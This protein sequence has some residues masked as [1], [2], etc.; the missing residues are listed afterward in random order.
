MLFG[1][2]QDQQ[3]CIM[4][5]ILV[6]LIIMQL[7]KFGEPSLKIPVNA[8]NAKL[9]SVAFF[10]CPRQQMWSQLGQRMRLF[11]KWF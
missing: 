6:Q 1:N 9:A 2:I 7:D 8:R 11:R 4:D 10:F 5:L 3:G